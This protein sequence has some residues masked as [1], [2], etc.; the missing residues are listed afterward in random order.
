MSNSTTS[1]SGQPPLV[2]LFRGPVTFSTWQMLAGFII[3]TAFLTKAK[4]VDHCYDVV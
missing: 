2:F 1:A 3:Y 4:T